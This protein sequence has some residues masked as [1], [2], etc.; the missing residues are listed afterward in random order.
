MSA[1]YIRIIKVVM[2]NN[3]ISIM[4][5]NEADAFTGNSKEFEFRHTVSQ[6]LKADCVKQ[7]VF[8]F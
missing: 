1:Y 4:G 3:E 2:K 6:K 7:L 8:E 5:E